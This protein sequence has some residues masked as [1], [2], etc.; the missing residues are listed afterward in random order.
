M[1]APFA[2]LAFLALAPGCAACLDQP[3]TPVTFQIVNRFDWPI[4][5]RDEFDQLG[6]N[7]QRDASG[8][9]VDLAEWSECECEE[10]SRACTTCEC[11]PLETWARRVEPGGTL[12]RVWAGEYRGR[13][14]ARCLGEV[15]PCLG[16]R[17]PAQPS[18]YRLKLCWAATLPGVP[19][20]QERF[21]ATFPAELTCSTQTFALPALGPVVIETAAPPACA[22]A[23]DCPAG[24]MCLGGRCSATCLPHGVP[25]LGGEW[26]L[27]I[28]VPDNAG[29]FEV[30]ESAGARIYRGTG[31]VA[32]VRYSAGNTNLSL[33]RAGPNGIDLEATLYYVLPGQRALPLR[34]GETL[35]LT[36]VDHPGGTRA[37]ARAVTVSSGGKLLLAADNGFGGPV[38][39]PQALGEFKVTPLAE[40]FACDS[41]DCG[42]RLHRRMRFESGE[43]VVELE[44]GKAATFAAGGETYE[45]VATANYADE[46]SGCGPS[47]MTPYLWMIKR[48]L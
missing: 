37:R 16:E 8:E 25:K 5:V 27:E 43:Q 9:W 24:Q 17:R 11:D 20:G 48:G 21:R 45:A 47:P 10:C 34:V 13:E 4:Y 15:L 1:R 39:A 7:V 31:E 41:G 2:A 38:L 6:L 40:V 33:K 32:N 42:K 18:I 22:F 30:E 26:T 35:K 12:E 23:V 36:V 3:A 28:G 19:Q 44:P 14:S 46:V 29:F